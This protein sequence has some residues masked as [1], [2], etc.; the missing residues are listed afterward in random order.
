MVRFAHVHP[1]FDFITLS[2]DAILSASSKKA[3]SD[4]G[5]DGD[6]EG[7]QTIVNIIESQLE[8]LK[9]GVSQGPQKFNDDIDLDDSYDQDEDNDDEDDDDQLQDQDDDEKDEDD[10]KDDKST[11]AESDIEE[12]DLKSTPISD[13]P[14]LSKLLQQQ[15][16]QELNTKGVEFTGDKSYCGNT[17]PPPKGSLE[18]RRFTL[19]SQVQLLGVKQ[20]ERNTARLHQQQQPHPQPQPQ[21]QPKQQLHPDRFGVDPD[22]GHSLQPFEYMRSVLLSQ[23]ISETRL[24]EFSRAYE[25]IASIVEDQSNGQLTIQPFGSVPM[26]LATASSDLDCRLVP[27]PIYSRIQ[28][29]NDSKEKNF[30]KKKQLTRYQGALPSQ[31]T[32]HQITQNIYPLP[33]LPVLNP[34]A[35]LNFLTGLSNACDAYNLTFIRKLLDRGPVQLLNVLLDSTK[36]P[37][38]DDEN[39]TAQP[40]KTTNNNNANS[41][42]GFNAEEPEKDDC[43]FTAPVEIDLVSSADQPM[44][45]TELFRSM[46]SLS[47]YSHPLLILIKTWAKNRCINDAQFG[48]LN[49]FSLSIMV[50]FFLQIQGELPV[51]HTNTYENPH[52]TPPTL[53]SKPREVEDFQIVKNAATTQ[54]ESTPSTTTTSF[55]L[56]TTLHTIPINE[57][58][59]TKLMTKKYQMLYEFPTNLI[60]KPQVHHPHEKR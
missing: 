19:Q 14:S 59:T 22:F 49:S 34:H 44:A 37:E 46:L 48:F 3:H 39:E 60:T 1:T 11:K 56:P 45:K 43:K 25:H 24:T 57:Q 20:Q 28:N 52:I 55:G 31:W 41:F 29:I 2:A 50:F 42:D 4:V 26:G 5:D 47:P 6:G 32:K 58:Q 40:T 38:I 30:K 13:Q 27:N 18:F 8:L 21:P 36:P 35:T 54:S 15:S 33:I 7:L 9:E 17:I 51:L 10:E 12:K 53:Q 23:Q 16:Q